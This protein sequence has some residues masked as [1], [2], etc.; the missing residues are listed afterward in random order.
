MLRLFVCLG[1]FR[2]KKGRIKLRFQFLME[3]RFYQY[4][5]EAP[6]SEFPEIHAW[7][8]SL[9]LFDV[10]PFRLFGH[11][12]TQNVASNCVFSF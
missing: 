7:I 6:A 11:F 8:H 4:Q 3:I 9:V 5:H 12:Q 1:V 10:A 2:C